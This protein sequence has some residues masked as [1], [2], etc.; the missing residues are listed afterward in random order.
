MN[1]GHRRKFSDRRLFKRRRRRKKKNTTNEVKTNFL[2][3][4]KDLHQIFYSVPGLVPLIKEYVA[5]D[6]TFYCFGTL[7]THSSFFVAEVRNMRYNYEIIRLNCFDMSKHLM[8][9]TLIEQY[10]P[11]V[12][13]CKYA[14]CYGCSVYNTTFCKECPLILNLPESLV[15]HVRSFIY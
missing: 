10:Y 15:D 13:G 9:I 14:E 2:F 4:E 5:D 11:G 8:R 6:Y 1:S 12:F 7:R 3:F